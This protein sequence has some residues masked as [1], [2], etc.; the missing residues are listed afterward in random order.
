MAASDAAGQGISSA[1]GAIQRD[2]KKEKSEIKQDGK[3]L[4]KEQRVEDKV[5]RTITKGTAKVGMKI[6]QGVLGVVDAST[7]A[8]EDIRAK[9]SKDAANVEKERADVKLGAEKQVDEANQ[10]TTEYVADAELKGDENVV[11][12]GTKYVTTKVFVKLVNKLQLFA[13]LDMFCFHES[14]IHS[15]ICGIFHLALLVLSDQFGDLLLLA[16]DRL[17]QLSVLL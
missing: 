6:K 4:K 1:A 16:L 17:L 10:A 12:L 3:T 9:M 14:E 13:V 8:A 7:A 11:D 5:M 15:A 2:A